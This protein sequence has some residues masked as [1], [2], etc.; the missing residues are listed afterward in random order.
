[1]ENSKK[2]TSTSTKRTVEEQKAAQ[3]IYNQR[4]RDKK[5]NDEDYKNKTREY[6]NKYYKINQEKVNEYQRN[7]QREV[8]Y[9]AHKKTTKDADLNALLPFLTL[10][11]SE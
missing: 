5:R 6:Q 10:D 7:Y 1:M 8:Y 2:S 3:I 4:Y 11:S 9:P